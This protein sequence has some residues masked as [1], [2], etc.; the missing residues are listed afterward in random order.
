MLDE[1]VLV[2]GKNVMYLVCLNE[3]FML[4]YSTYCG[5]WRMSFYALHTHTQ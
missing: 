4:Y 1:I 5:Y 2:I 3:L